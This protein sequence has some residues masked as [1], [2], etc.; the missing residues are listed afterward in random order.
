MKTVSEQTAIAALGVAGSIVTGLIA[1]IRGQRKGAAEARE[2]NARAE[3]MLS[4][5]A[6][7][8]A[9][10]LRAELAI[11]R[12]ERRR[13]EDEHEVTRQRLATA[14]RGIAAAEREIAGLK[15]DVADLKRLLRHH[16]ITPPGDTQPEGVPVSRPA[17][18]E[19]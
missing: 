9:G 11:E 2:V 1:W 3:V 8:I 10:D 6:R 14:E 15:R 16:G 12:A 4:A 5:E 19:G 7:A 17:E 13:E 18:S